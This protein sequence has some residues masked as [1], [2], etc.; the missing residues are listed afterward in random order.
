VD[1]KWLVV[2]GE[3]TRVSQTLTERIREL[4]ERYAVPLPKLEEEVDEL[5]AKVAGH[6]AKMGVSL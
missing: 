5:A 2:Q 3:L 6:L 4:A 1:D